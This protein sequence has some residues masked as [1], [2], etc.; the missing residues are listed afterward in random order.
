[1]TTNTKTKKTYE[2]IQDLE[3]E[4]WK[5]IKGYEGLYEVS[6]MGR[7]KSFFSGRWK[8]VK[9]MTPNPNREGYIRVKL[10]KNKTTS[11]KFVH[12][13]VYESFHGYIPKYV[14]YGI[15]NGH[16][17]LVINHKDENPANNK[18]DNLEIVS[19]TQNINYGTAMERRRKSQ[20]NKRNSKKVYQYTA[21]GK[22]VKVWPSTMECNRNG[23]DFRNVA[24]CCAGTRKHCN[25][26][27]WSYEPIENK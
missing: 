23:F 21:D 17:T 5:P 20:T 16:K 7:V 2:S 3:G 15:G 4:V 26:F 11:Q 24:A 22:L 6:N 9:I 27:L 12:R 14:L 10:T 19:T 1:M 13:L 25:G 18:L 8:K